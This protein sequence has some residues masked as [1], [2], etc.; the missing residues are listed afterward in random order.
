MPF[1]I[2]PG[3]RAHHLAD[4]DLVVEDVRSEAP[5]LVGEGGGILRTVASAKR[6]VRRHHHSGAAAILDRRRI[7]RAGQGA[8]EE[9]R[10]HQGCQE[11]AHQNH[12]SPF[13]GASR[14]LA[15]GKGVPAGRFRPQCAGSQMLWW[16]RRSQPAL[17][18]SCIA[19]APFNSRTRFSGEMSAMDS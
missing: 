1:E 11:A 6:L 16:L 7:G 10:D 9:Q 15:I 3:G 19:A 12:R 13:A 5:D 2:E 8:A 17:G 4:D 18:A 14:R